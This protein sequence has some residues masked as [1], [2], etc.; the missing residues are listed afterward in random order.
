MLPNSENSPALDFQLPYY[1]L[2]SHYVSSDL[3]IPKS[4]IRFG[5]SGMQFAA[6]PKAAI[7][8]YRYSPR[9]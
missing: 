9:C 7:N 8:K 5:H 4:F 3:P 2:I 6:M 1:P